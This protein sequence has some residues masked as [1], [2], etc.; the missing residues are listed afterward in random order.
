MNMEGS[1]KPIN[2]ERLWSQILNIVDVERDTLID[3]DL[4]GNIKLKPD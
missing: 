1:N 3:K 2:F 4:I